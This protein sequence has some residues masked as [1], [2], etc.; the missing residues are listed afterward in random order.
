MEP[1]RFKLPE[2]SFKKDEFRKVHHKVENVSHDFFVVRCNSCRTFSELESLVGRCSFFKNFLRK[3]R[4]LFQFESLVLSTVDASHYTQ[5][6][7]SS[8]KTAPLH[9]FSHQDTVGLHGF[10][11]GFW[12]GS[13]GLHGQHM[14]EMLGSFPSYHILQ[15]IHLAN[16]RPAAVSGFGYLRVGSVTKA[17]D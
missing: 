5:S 8:N 4:Q 10:I 17:M 11:G 14:I 12:H 7:F 15:Q 9:R 16:A 6:V 13:A 1:H 2:T 3:L